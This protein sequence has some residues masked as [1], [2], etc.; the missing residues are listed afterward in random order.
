MFEAEDRWI[1]REWTNLL[2]ARMT[3][4]LSRIK[5]LFGGVGTIL[6][7]LF[8]LSALNLSN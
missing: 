8:L 2:S 4:F 1:S 3:L 5:P 6:M 7:L